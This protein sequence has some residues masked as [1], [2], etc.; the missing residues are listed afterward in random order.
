MAIV[1]FF[2]PFVFAVVVKIG[3]LV[4]FHYLVY[5]MLLVVMFVVIV[6]LLLKKLKIVEFAPYS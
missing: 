3:R 6:F 5:I 1:V 4:C 2:R